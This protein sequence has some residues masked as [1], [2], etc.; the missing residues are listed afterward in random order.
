MAR[1]AGRG[2]GR[3]QGRAGGRGDNGEG[4]KP[5]ENEEEVVGSQD[6]ENTNYHE[7][8]DDASLSQSQSQEQAQP[9]NPQAIHDLLQTLLQHL[10]AKQTAGEQP[11]AQQGEEQ[12]AAQQAGG[13]REQALGGTQ[14]RTVAEYRAD[15][16]APPNLRSPFAWEI[17]DVPI[18]RDFK[19]P[20]VATF[21]GSTD[22]EQHISM[23][24]RHMELIT[25][26]DAL[27]CRAFPST[28]SGR[29][30]QWFTKLEPH[31]VANFTVLANRI[32]ARFAGSRKV[33]RDSASLLEIV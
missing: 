1:S 21:D 24:E 33:G 28:L 20:T 5:M 11:Q 6:G 27:W 12:L 18:P 32:K 2:R 13:Q 22:P 19:P 16:E 17:L 15:R 31:S 25:S 3:G 4:A 26:E 10:Q 14:D 7:E 29:A 8:H 30:Q 23:F 9:M